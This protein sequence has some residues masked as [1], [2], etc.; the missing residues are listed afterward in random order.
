MAPAS[1]FT[2]G[3]LT[4]TLLFTGG[5]TVVG[6][7]YQPPD[8]TALAPQWQAPL[9]TGSS[10]LSLQEW[11]KGFADEGL[12]ALVEATLS[13]NFNLEAMQ[14]A[15]EAA[16]AVLVVQQGAELPQATLAGK[17]GRSGNTPNPTVPTVTSKSMIVDAAWELDLFGR[18]KLATE[19]AEAKVA[20][21]EADLQA[22][23]ISLTAEVARLYS[24]LRGCQQLVTLLQSDVAS[25]Q[26]TAEIVQKSVA[27]GFIAAGE[28]S[29]SQAS[30]ADARSQ[31]TAQQATC[32]L[33][34]KNLVALSGLAEPEVRNLLGQGGNKWPQ[35]TAF[36]LTTLPAQLLSQRADLVSAE[37]ELMAA[38]AEIGVAEAN[39]YP[40]LSLLGNVTIGVISQ[41][42]K[43]T[44]N[45][46]WSFGPALSL[47]ILD[48]GVLAA[49]VKGAKARH[50]I[51]LANYRQAVQNAV[52]EVESALV[53]LVSSQTRRQ[54]AHL[55]AREYA[56]YFQA[57]E[58][59]WRKGG[60]SLLSLEETRRLTLNA[61]KAV[62]Q[63]EMQQVQSW[64][65]LYKALGGGWQQGEGTDPS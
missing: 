11:W 10:K 28:G 58:E 42:S 26:K 54:D 38:N 55:A 5:C 29:L 14:G 7:D 6:P 25:R 30:Y 31:L 16:R 2:T 56:N 60:I 44:D 1:P 19:S 9:P 12:S 51:A 64:I 17:I 33:T 20:A 40:R 65:N 52:K 18:V 59:N 32:E 39:R 61:Q 63:L 8:Q 13:Q 47:P 48:G 35:A 50:R 57:S 22:L 15:I 62:V 3:L 4:L 37:Q 43:V 41:G 23:R 46:P 34:I 21:R 53:N 36:T 45:Q 49:N 24:D 27:A